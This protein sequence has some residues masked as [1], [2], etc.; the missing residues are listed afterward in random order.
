ME[1]I[2]R[3][4]QR[5]VWGVKRPSLSERRRLKRMACHQE[6]VCT[7]GKE[8]HKIT[9][10]DVGFGGFRV[11]SQ[12]SLGERGTLHHLRRLPTDFRRH[13]TGSYGTGL[14]VK[15]AWEKRDAQGFEVGLA[16]PEAPGSMRIEWFRELLREFGLDEQGVFSQRNSRRHR[17]RLPATLLVG[18]NS[19]LTGTMLDLSEG[20]GLLGLEHPVRL[21][22]EGQL[23]V[24]WGVKTLV[25][26]VSVVGVRENRISNGGPPCWHSLK[27]QEP[28]GALAEELLMDW[29]QELSRNE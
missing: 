23:T 27:F 3:K 12:R 9:V 25:L 4:A 10:V 13:L 15:V 26:G 6:F 21:G 20:G 18:E 5:Y 11:R 8:S 16:V 29:L 7:K 22:A 14:M 24:K 1:N 17:C 19:E 28:L 2:L